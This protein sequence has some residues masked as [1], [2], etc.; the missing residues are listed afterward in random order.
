MNEKCGCTVK[1]TNTVA[2]NIQP[3]SV[4][5]EKNPILTS[6]TEKQHRGTEGTHIQS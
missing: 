3:V 4:R 2:R 1:T 5:C 6:K